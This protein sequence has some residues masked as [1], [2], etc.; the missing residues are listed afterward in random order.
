MKKFYSIDEIPVPK[1]AEIEYKQLADEYL[2]S[3]DNWTLCKRQNSSEAAFY[4]IPII[5]RQSRR[6]AKADI[7]Q[8]CVWGDV[9]G[10]RERKA[11]RSLIHLL[12]ASS[13][14][15]RFTRRVASRRSSC[16]FAQRVGISPSEV[17]SPSRPPRRRAKRVRFACQ[18]FSRNF[19]FFEFA[20]N[21][22]RL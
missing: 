8:I 22:I 6:C 18:Q 10:D 4:I 12:C 21:E 17:T 3:S 11:S 14:A 19:A 5:I 20:Q 16:V 15:S 9:P 7:L 2:E 1:K 13:F